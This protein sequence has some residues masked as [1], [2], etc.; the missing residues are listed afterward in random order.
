[1][2]PETNEYREQRVQSLNKL[3]EMGYEPYGMK[4]DHAD[5]KDVRENFEEGKQLV[6][7]CTQELE[8]IQQKIE[9]VVSGASEPPQVEPM[10]IIT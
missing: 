5:L 9:K 4:Y 7:A 8:A 3:R 6:A 10:D 2:S 1:M